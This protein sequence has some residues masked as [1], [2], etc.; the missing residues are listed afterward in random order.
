MGRRVHIAYQIEEEHLDELRSLLDKGIEVS[1]EEP[2]DNYEV[3][4]A[5]RPDPELLESGKPD[6]VVIPFAGV[7]SK[8][9]KLLSDHPEVVLHNLHYNADS[10]AE[11]ALSL[12]LSAAKMIIPVD[13]AFREHRWFP[14]DDLADPLQLSGKTALLLGYGYIGKRIGRMA[15][16]FNMEVRA[17]RKNPEKESGTIATQHSSE[18]LENLLP[19]ADALLI[20]LPL[21]E[22]TEGIIGKGELARLP[23]HAVLVNVGRGKIVEEEPLYRALRDRKIKAAGI[24]VWYQYPERKGGGEPSPQPPSSY[25]FHALDNVVMSPHRAGWSEDTEMDRVRHLARLLNRFNEGD[26][27]RNVVDLEAGY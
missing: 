22:E 3:L 5:G 18:Q 9:R 14:Q 16:G 17:V 19:E 25:P 8:T 13:R 15:D 26:T 24:D 7:P 11:M 23:D 4:V 27:G 2:P 6:R 10:T 20:S 12:L 21:T 1:A